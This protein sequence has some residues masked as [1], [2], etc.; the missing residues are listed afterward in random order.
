MGLAFSRTYRIGRI[1]T[2]LYLCRRWGGNSDAALSTEKI[3]ANNLY[4]DRLRTIE[5]KARLQQNSRGAEERRD[6]SLVRFFLRQIDTWDEARLH[7]KELQ[8]V[9][10]RDLLADG[11][12]I[13]VQFNPAPSCRADV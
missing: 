11:L 1:F 9:K 3:N 10:T 12:A 7:F 5:L 4:K 8:Q 13:K 6:G 2:E